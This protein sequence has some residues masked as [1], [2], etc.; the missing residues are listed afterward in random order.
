[1]PFLYEITINQ[2]GFQCHSPKA[3][4]QKSLHTWNSVVSLIPWCTLAAAIMWIGEEC[5]HGYPK[6]WIYQ[7]IKLKYYEDIYFLPSQKLQHRQVPASLFCRSLNNVHKGCILVNKL[8]HK[9]CSFL[10]ACIEKETATVRSNMSHLP[11]LFSF[12]FLVL[13]VVF[14][15]FLLLLLLFCFCFVNS[16][17][18]FH[19]STQMSFSWTRQT[20]QTGS[21][22]GALVSCSIRKT[23]GQLPFLN[24]SFSMSGLFC[25]IM[26]IT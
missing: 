15:V 24:E 19:K 22:L 4:V 7:I 16:T 18:G 9:R 17:E 2:K 8:L 23:C 20:L 5:W 6:V 12:W 25:F 21:T 13:W 11:V 14:F 26:I 1:M 10:P 3:D